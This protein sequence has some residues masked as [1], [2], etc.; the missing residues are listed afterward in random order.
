MQDLRQINRLFPRGMCEECWQKRCF[1]AQAF[2]REHNYGLDIESDK[3]E[4]KVFEQGEI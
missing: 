4:L 3:E 1:E 2:S